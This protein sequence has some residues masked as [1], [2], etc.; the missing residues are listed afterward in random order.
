MA[1]NV[2]SNASYHG[3]A[4]S[5]DRAAP[6]TDCCAIDG[7]VDGAALSVDGANP[8]IARDIYIQE[9]FSCDMHC[10]HIITVSN[11]R[12]HILK[13]LRRQGLS[14]LLAYIVCF[15]QQLSLKLGMLF[16]HDMI[17]EIQGC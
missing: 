1:L 15:M 11:Q 3:A 4:I 10:K 8:S 9:N 7:S 13:A 14:L 12:L 17:S 5:T 6:S 2:L 16:L